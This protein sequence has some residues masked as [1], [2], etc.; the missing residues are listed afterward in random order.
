MKDTSKL[1]GG[2]GLNLSEF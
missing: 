2:W 1:C